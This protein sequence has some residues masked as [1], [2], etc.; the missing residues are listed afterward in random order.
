MGILAAALETLEM[1]DAD[2]PL[3]V[4]WVILQMPPQTCWQEKWSKTAATGV[5][6]LGPHKG[7]SALHY[8]SFE[9]CKR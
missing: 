9:I 8:E 3:E 7:K 4:T 6:V 2:A 1:E 5:I